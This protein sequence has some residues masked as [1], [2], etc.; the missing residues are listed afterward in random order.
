MKNLVLL[1]SSLL[2]PLNTTLHGGIT[3]KTLHQY[4][5]I[6]EGESVNSISANGSVLVNN[7]T[8][9]DAI[10]VNGAL[11]A[12]G[13]TIGSMDV[14]GGVKIENSIIHGQ[15]MINGALKAEETKF[16]GLL[17]IAS[18]KTTLNNC[19]L[20]NITIRKNGKNN[21]LQTVELNGKTTIK[22]N[23]VFEVNGGVVV[24]TNEVILLGQVIRGQIQ[25]Q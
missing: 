6:F 5:Q 11:L 22:G 4:S 21:P 1:L 16:E 25:Q 9:K 13:S 15:T 17:S 8:V 20:N 18:E 10:T 19:E 7:S 24:V 3:M 12:I 23:I 2:A 14:N